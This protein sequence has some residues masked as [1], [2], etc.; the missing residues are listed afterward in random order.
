M[1]LLLSLVAVSLAVITVTHSFDLAFYY[2]ALEIGFIAW[3]CVWRPRLYDALR[4][5]LDIFLDW[6]LLQQLLSR[7]AVEKT[8]DADQYAAVGAVSGGVVVFALGQWLSNLTTSIF[9]RTIPFV[10]VCVAVFAVLY[11]LFSQFG[12][13]YY[14]LIWAGIA[15]VVGVAAHVFDNIRAIVDAFVS[16]LLIVY[17]VY[18]I[19]HYPQFTVPGDLFADIPALYAA[20]GALAVFRIVVQFV[21]VLCLR[22]RQSEEQTPGEDSEGDSLLGS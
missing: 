17:S 14:L 11:F 4:L 13:D 15:L 10:N 7:L 5:A 20:V 16:T 12:D 19:V 2:V 3:I 9:R 18:Q 21:V 8:L 6:F 22:T 1:A